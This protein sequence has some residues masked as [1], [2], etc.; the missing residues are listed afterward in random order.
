M[1]AIETC[2]LR[3]KLKFV[4]HKDMKIH[5]PQAETP[6]CFVVTGLDEDLNLAM[7]KAVKH[8]VLFISE[9]NRIDFEQALMICGAAVDFAVTQIVDGVKGIHAMIPKSIIKMEG[10]EFWNAD[11]TCF[12]G[13][14]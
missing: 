7:K 11:G 9:K 14:L 1:T 6:T 2:G 3:C 4:L 12:Y 13:A 8:A 5:S 10:H